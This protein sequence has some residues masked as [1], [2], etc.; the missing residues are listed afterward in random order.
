[1]NRRDLLSFISGISLLFAG[2]VSAAPAPR[3]PAIA[4]QQQIL[5]WLQKRGELAV[6]A[7]DLAK[8]Q[9][10]ASYM[11]AGKLT[12]EQLTVVSQQQ[13]LMKTA[14]LRSQSSGLSSKLQRVSAADASVTKTVK[15]LA[16][17]IDFPDL[18]YDNNRLTSA[19]TDMYYSSYPA[20]HYNDLLFSDAGF[21]GPSGQ[22]L[23]SAYQYYQAVSGST[24]YF[25]GAVK[26]W[27]TASHDA[28][29]YGANDPDNN[30]SDIRATDLVE[31]AVA[32]AA[33]TMSADELAQ[34]DVED[35]YDLDGDGVLDE[36]DGI[37]DHVMVF[38]SSIGE[39]SGGGVLGSD[40]IWSH[41]FY[42]P[43]SGGYG[44]LIPGTSK[45]VFGYTIQPID[46]SVGVCVHEFGHDLGLP[47][48]YDTGA[49]EDGEPVAL[50]SLMSSGS[51]T[52][53]PGGSA[54]SGF[55]PYARDFLQQRYKGLWLNQQTIDYSAL[56]ADGTDVVLNQAT[57]ANNI[58][59]LAITLPVGTV[60]ITAP[61]AGAYQYYSGEG[62]NLNN[63]MSFD[64]QLPSSSSLTL[65][66]KARWDTEKYYDYAQVLVDGVAIAGNYTL[67]SNSINNAAN[68]ITGDSSTLSAADNNG[69]VTLSYD[70][71]AYAGLNKQ[72]SLVYKTDESLGGEGFQIDNLLINSGS[73][74]V[75]ADNAEQDN[76]AVTLGGFIRTGDTR[77]GKGRSYLVQLR[78]Y[79]GVDSGL[80]LAAYD[81]G[82]LVWLRDDEVSD[83][84][85]SEH[86]GKVFIGVVDADQHVIGTES[87]LVQVHDA[88]FSLYNQSYYPN[89]SYRLANSFF[90]DREDYSG[91]T[92]PQAGIILPALGV[93]IE[94]VSQEQDSS[95]ATV[96][97]AL[98]GTS[99][100]AALAAGISVSAQNTT[101]SF[102]GSASGGTAPYHYQWS[103]GDGNSSSE[104]NP[105]HTYTSAGAYAVALTV[106]DA[107]AQTATITKQITLSSTLTA[108]FGSSTSGLTVQF[109]NQ[110]S[111]GSGSLSYSWSFGDG[112]S[113]TLTSP[114]HTYSA[115]GSYTVTLT[116]SDSN[117]ASSSA[118]ASVAVSAPTASTSSSGGGSM[119]LWC[120]LG[121]A[122]TAFGRRKSLLRSVV[123]NA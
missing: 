32:K 41:R 114:T 63:A 77:P 93:T 99:Q 62:N 3:D 37:I 81:P 74:S 80:Q 20:S 12:K 86:P 15:V 95:Q 55:S 113:S 38:H 51:W 53:S 71:S 120:L 117:N 17:L 60:A 21:S 84:N 83:N 59:Q 10:L 33:A 102:S 104:Q 36:P 8:Q 13:Q 39:E 108:A 96:R 27:F 75:F 109:T 6:D 35:P 40:A 42:V 100:P 68:I 79:N 116:V 14:L 106:T 16:V 28:A 82:V 122:L 31:E 64:V 123:A 115:A 112:S 46:S 107:A 49:V 2:G 24:F 9:A 56:T 43:S 18:P 111:G 94:V 26:G 105:T 4:N 70:L 65:T 87:T 90:D 11:A 25:S 30:D 67:S 78:S 121:L 92:M 118:S 91:S 23:E 101:V 72:I 66:M 7:S 57:D 50:W 97:V 1:M 89:D 54:P 22:N 69:W 98:A 45:R 73:S 34:Y 29:Y 19:D 44:Q 85:V 119:G 88:A 52:G 61:Y 5:Y 58:N 47:D 48:E 76:A 110:S 103:F